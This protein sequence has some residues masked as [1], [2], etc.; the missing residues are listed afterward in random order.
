M[1]FYIPYN[2]KLLSTIMMTLETYIQNCTGKIVTVFIKCT[3]TRTR[4]TNTAGEKKT[5]F[6]L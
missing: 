1:K 4:T 5:L 3:Q 6:S 2:G